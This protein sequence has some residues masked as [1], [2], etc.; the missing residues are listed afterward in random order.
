MRGHRQRDGSVGWVQALGG[1]SVGGVSVG[2]VTVVV[3][4]FQDELTLPWVNGDWTDPAENRKKEIR[5]IDL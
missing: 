4:G 3:F 2:G 1:V 5:D